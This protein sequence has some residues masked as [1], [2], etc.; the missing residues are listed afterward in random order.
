MPATDQP[1][2]NS[3]SSSSRTLNAAF[4]RQIVISVSALFAIFFGLIMFAHFSEFPALNRMRVL[5]P[6]AGAVPLMGSILLL[7]AVLKGAISSRVALIVLT[8]TLTIFGNIGVYQNGAMTYALGSAFLLLLSMM[9]APPKWAYLMGIGAATLPVLVQ[10]ISPLPMDEGVSHRV[11]ATLISIILPMHT[12]LNSEKDSKLVR[13]LVFKQLL[14]SGIVCW[15]TWH[16]LFQQTSETALFSLFLSSIILFVV[17]WI[18]SPS[19]P[20]VLALGM[21][22][23][24]LFLFAL[25]RNGADA[26]FALPMW[27][28]A[29]FLLLDLSIAAFVSSILILTAVFSVDVLSTASARGLISACIFYVMLSIWFYFRESFVLS[30]S[31]FSAASLKANS[32]YILTG[33][34]AS[35]LLLSIVSAPFFIAGFDLEA[36]GS[37]IRWVALQLFIFTLLTV[38]VWS[39]LAHQ[40]VVEFEKDQL[41]LELEKHVIQLQDANAAAEAAHKALSD[42]QERQSQVFSIIG[43]ELRTPLASIRMMYDEIQ[44]NRQ[45][46]YG[47]QIIHTHDAVMGILDD[48]KI[49]TQPDR[50]RENKKSMS[51]PFTIAERT[52]TSLSKWLNEQSFVVHLSCDNDS[53]QTVEINSGALRQVITNL[54]KNAALHSQGTDV[55]V[56][57][58]GSREGG[59]LQLILK[60]EDNGRGIPETQRGKIFDAFGRGDTTADGTGLGLYIIKELCEMLAGDIEY[61]DSDRGGAGFRLSCTLPIA[62]KTEGHEN[63]AGSTQNLLSGKKILFAEDQLT[64]QALT[65][66]L[67]IRQD[68]EPTVANNGVEALKLFAKQNF[69]IVLTDAMMPEMD[70]Y[71]L[72][73][74]LRKKGFIGP[75]IAV[76]AA[77]IGQETENLLASGVDIV[78]TKPID[79]KLLNAHL[80]SLSIQ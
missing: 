61:F 63:K 38:G 20:L 37:G 41:R 79:I 24:I 8:L 50:V 55:W 70:G 64:L 65:Q 34:A 60:V 52:V 25:D 26:I 10:L 74:E 22:P 45:H 11:F 40:A 39:Y 33:I 5:N 30:S 76:T 71:T 46:P 32:R 78:M 58:T 1:L 19:K 62:S 21:A 66:S 68:A 36:N 17:F 29:T 13:W 69:D 15:A 2:Q 31:A 28:L 18:R 67:L 56:S 35:F 23:V 59:L 77:V 42:R 16:L 14:I 27:M 6:V 9:S 57:L 12:L 73:R 7:I 48:L 49:V 44:L 47:P 4:V 75:I 80:E 51:A 54:V 43:H 3:Q 72:S 53:Y